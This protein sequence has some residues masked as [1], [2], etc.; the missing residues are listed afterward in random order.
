M[1][2]F[3]IGFNRGRRMQARLLLHIN[4]L[5]EVRRLDLIMVARLATAS[6]SGQG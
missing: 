4:A 6:F 5:V 1:D 2:Q 3:G